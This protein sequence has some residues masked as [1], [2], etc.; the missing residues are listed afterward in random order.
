ML[1]HKRKTQEVSNRV[2]PPGLLAVQRAHRKSPPSR[3]IRDKEGV[4]KG[5]P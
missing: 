1:I 3:R 4:R 5:S 2:C